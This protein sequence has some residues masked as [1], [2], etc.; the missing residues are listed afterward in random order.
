MERKFLVKCLCLSGVFY[1]IV[2]ILPLKYYT[3]YLKSKKI[4][5]NIT[6]NPEYY[7]SLITKSIARIEKFTFWNCNCLNK[8]LISKYLC[9]KLGI[10]NK[11]YLTIYKS[12]KGYENAHASLLIDNRIHY[13]QLS[14]TNGNTRCYNISLK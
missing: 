1:L 7:I 10:V 8:V 12:S 13:L 3:K 4:D 6:I 9:D 14:F 2:L 5:S 11:L